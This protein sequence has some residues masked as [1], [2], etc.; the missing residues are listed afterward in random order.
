VASGAVLAEVAGDGARRGRRRW[1]G[2]RR[3]R[4]G[5]RGEVEHAGGLRGRRGRRRRAGTRAR[6]SARGSEAARPAGAVENG[7]E[8]GRR[9]SSLTASILGLW[10][11]APPLL[12]FL[13]LAKGRGEA[14]RAVYNSPLVPAFSPG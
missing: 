4:R 2:P 13:D 12:L 7:G 1:L 9:R 14:M 6:A 11:R 8:R 5:R 3:G 10:G